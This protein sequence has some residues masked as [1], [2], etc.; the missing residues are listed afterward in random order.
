MVKAVTVAA[1]MAVG[2]IV[3]AGQALEVATAQTK[4]TAATDAIVE[5]VTLVL[6]AAGDHGGNPCWRSTAVAITAA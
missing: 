1:M 4:M 2:D 5:A 3:A 6:A